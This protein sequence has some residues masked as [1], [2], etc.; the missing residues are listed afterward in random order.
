MRINEVE[1][2][3]LTM[4][5][6]LACSELIRRLFRMAI[7]IYG[8][9]QSSFSFLAV[10]QVLIEERGRTLASEKENEV[11]NQSISPEKRGEWE[12]QLH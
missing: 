3:S 8:F 9:C 2:F 5:S 12:R 10:P 7:K 11:G 4:T 6:Q 1:Y